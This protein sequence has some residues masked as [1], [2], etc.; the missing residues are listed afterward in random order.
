MSM[1]ESVQIQDLGFR[2]Q[3]RFK[4]SSSAKPAA[5]ADSD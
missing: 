4:G 3:R 2:V 1:G 5:R